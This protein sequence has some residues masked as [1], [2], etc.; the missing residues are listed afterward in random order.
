MQ[1]KLR[2]LSPSNWC[3]IQRSI[4]SRKLWISNIK[5]NDKHKRKVNELEEELQKL[6]HLQETLI[7]HTPVN[8]TETSASKSKGNSKNENTA[9]VLNRDQQENIN[10]FTVINLQS[11]TN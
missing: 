7:Q 8:T 11:L 4:P 1:E 10:L 2:S 6:K 3:N 5:N 9:S